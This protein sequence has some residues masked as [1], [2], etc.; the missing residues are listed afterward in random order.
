MKTWHLTLTR[1]THARVL[2]LKGVC[3]TDIMLERGKLTVTNIDLGASL[4]SPMV[5][6]IR[7]EESAPT[8]G[9]PAVVEQPV[10]EAPAVVEQPVVEAP[11]VVAE[12]PIVAEV[13]VK[14]D[15]AEE[16]VSE[17]E[18]I[19]EPE[20]DKVDEP[21]VKAVKEPVKT[22]RKRSTRKRATSK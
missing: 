2:K 7:V 22:K 10:V 21:A 18:T 5:R 13:E 15:V 1:A 6:V 16:P 20:S 14:A 19:M 9:T 4:A 17:P 12:A 8:I 11:A 3:G